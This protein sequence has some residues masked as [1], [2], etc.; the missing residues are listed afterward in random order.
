MSN[1]G[2]TD[3]ALSWLNL[4]DISYERKNGKIYIFSGENGNLLA[5]INA[6][7]NI[8]DVNEILDS[9][10]DNRSDNQGIKVDRD[11]AEEFVNK[12]EKDTKQNVDSITFNEDSYDVKLEQDE[13]TVS[14]GENKELNADE[15]INKVN[16][17]KTTVLGT[18]K[19]NE[20]NKS[21]IDN[22]LNQILGEKGKGQV[23]LNKDGKY[24]VYVNGEK[25][26]ELEE[27]VT[28]SEALAE[29]NKKVND[30]SFSSD[31]VLNKQKTTYNLQQQ[32]G[33]NYKV[34]IN[35]DDFKSVTKL[36]NKAKG[37]LNDESSLYKT[38]MLTDELLS[39]YQ[40][41]VD[42]NKDPKDRL[43][44]TS[45]LLDNVTLNIE[46]SL[47]AYENI[48]HNLGIVFNSIVAD[49]FK[50]NSYDKN[51]EIEGYR[52]MSFAE[53]KAALD[54]LTK[55][56]EDALKELNGEL[57]KLFPKSY[58]NRNID[59]VP[60]EA[61][62]I[63]NTLIECCVGSEYEGDS[64]FFNQRIG[65]GS[66]SVSL[67]ARF[68][69]FSKENNLFEKLDDYLIEG[70][71]WVDSGMSSLNETILK[72]LM[73]NDQYTR[74]GILNGHFDNYKPNDYLFNE[75]NN[76][77]LLKENGIYYID[78]NPN[79]ER[80]YGS[81]TDGDI[82]EYNYSN[83]RYY[84]PSDISYQL[85][86]YDKNV[87]K[88]CETAFL[89]RFCYEKAFVSK[90]YNYNANYIKESELNDLFKFDDL[91]KIN[92]DNHDNN[93]K[94]LKESMSDWYKEQYS[95][96]SRVNQKTKEYDIQGF[97]NSKLEDYNSLMSDISLV[98]ESLYRYKQYS[99]LLPFEVEMEN[100]DYLDFLVK[101]YSKFKDNNITK[102]N[103]GYL[104]QEEIALYAYLKSKDGSR[105]ASY[106][107]ALQDTINQRKGYEEAALRIYKMNKNGE[108]VI[109]LLTMGKYGFAD[110]VDK[111]G[112]GIADF[113]NG[114]ASLFMDN[115]FG[116]IRTSDDYRDMYMLSL[117]MEDNVYN[118][119]LSKTFRE[120]LQFNYKANTS[121]GNMAIPTIVSFI[122]IV[123][124]MSPILLGVSAAGSSM[125][126]AKLSGAGD[127]RALIYG[128]VSGASEVLLERLMGGIM[129]LNG[130]TEAVNG[131]LGLLSSMAD[132]AK[133][134]FVQAFFD[135]AMR[136]IILQE[137]FD[138]SSVSQEAVESALMALYTA[139]VMNTVTTCAVKIA[140]EVIYWS[141]SQFNNFSE[142]SNYINNKVANRQNL[143][144]ISPDVAEKMGIKLNDGETL[145]Y[146][147][148]TN[149]YQ[150]VDK[151]GYRFN[152]P[153]S[154][155]KYYDGDIASDYAYVYK[156]RQRG[157]IVETENGKIKY[158]NHGHYIVRANNGQQV[159]IP[160]EYMNNIEGFV[161]DSKGNLIECNLDVDGQRITVPI[162]DDISQLDGS[163]NHA[164]EGVV[165]KGSADGGHSIDGL[166]G[167]NNGN[168]SVRITA[169]D[170]PSYN[171]SR[172]SNG[173]YQLSDSS[174]VTVNGD[175]VTRTSAPFSPD[176]STDLIDKKTNVRATQEVVFPDGSKVLIDSNGN[177][178]KDVGNKHYQ[179]MTP[180]D[181]KY[182]INKLY[183]IEVHKDGTISVIETLPSQSAP[184]PT[185][186]K[187]YVS[188]DGTVVGINSEN[189][190][191]I[192]IYDRIVYDNS[193]D[194]PIDNRAD[195]AND[196]GDNS[197]IYV[198]S[199][200]NPQGR[201]LSHLATGFPPSWDST[202]INDAMSQVIH[203]TVP[204]I[205]SST[206][207]CLYRGV[208]DGIEIEVVVS[209]DAATGEY[210]Y[211]ITGHPMK[212]GK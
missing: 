175:E 204:T 39:F 1:N 185:G 115:D 163:K 24:E 15:V 106:I 171:V 197:C 54:K 199:D 87:D 84:F 67:L 34:H 28:L 94:L 86:L 64:N 55:D 63:L 88:I 80:I 200:T 192:N 46:Y 100:K 134:E 111:F 190:D 2:F 194:T 179:M 68:N 93:I 172:N 6:S 65:S 123:K 107:K 151:N 102:D 103:Y 142:F 148:N 30:G 95:L 212:A 11:N 126:E 206:G 91:N 45:E 98:S 165:T 167:R 210:K 110:G 78:A 62:A 162:F 132:E 117:L 159:Y 182:Q 40:E 147:P 23:V 27:G 71:S 50:I 140:D 145:K 181:G 47:K 135:G 14:Y 90:D 144:D 138:L 154:M 21:V 82:N 193:G 183:S 191:S 136:A 92:F 149:S 36:H 114:I 26:L 152:I 4:Y 77:N 99:L 59:N 43:Q 208:V 180:T 3:E 116:K 198:W 196:I 157:I 141:P 201:R 207:N 128:I 169:V 61:F 73:E 173:T 44:K 9:I 49:I 105:A 53:R 177:Y 124:V 131:V 38:D 79:D 12:I 188:G 211:L 18:D 155:I 7:K 16:E 184:T 108:D 41:T 120:M 133:E 8:D 178:Y 31:S 48:D 146:N 156:M 70:K 166:I 85:Y 161:Y 113:F 170:T 186:D 83:G 76:N 81:N 52:K 58:G 158:D 125:R 127:A 109:D 32:T 153:D 96:Y 42:M 187:I 137:P 209:K 168:N 33:Q 176:S 174:V 13:L 29:I 195:Y 143:V 72:N 189:G 25:V 160:T 130:K 60:P 51:T 101:D 122:P 37:D 10:V 118:D 104:T 75:F 35:V 5:V 66:F 17:G 97:V 112:N 22:Y 56:Y 202:K 89:N 203:S 19:L 164:M 119:Q 20:E 205:N 139:G 74:K 121:I 150:K 129:G 57:D 69:T